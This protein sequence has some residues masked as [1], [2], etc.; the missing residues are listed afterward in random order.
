MLMSICPR[1]SPI[2]GAKFSAK[3]NGIQCN[4]VAQKPEL[5]MELVGLPLAV[6]HPDGIKP[7]IL[8]IG[9]SG[10]LGYPGVEARSA[11]QL[12]A[13]FAGAAVDGVPG[14]RRVAA[15]FASLMCHV[16]PAVLVL[17]AI[18]KDVGC[19]CRS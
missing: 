13:A 19:R 9:E 8:E 12:I 10:G 15:L 7:D 16:V 6:N 2:T 4:P 18:A 3:L 11:E 14:R 17:P 5:E 1:S